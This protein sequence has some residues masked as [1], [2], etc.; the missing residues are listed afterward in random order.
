MVL[1]AIF[2]KEECYT[3]SHFFTHFSCT[4]SWLL[5]PLLDQN[6]I[7]IHFISNA[8]YHYSHDIQITHGPSLFV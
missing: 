7:K 3:D 2:C 6:L 5:K 4:H 8:E 1:C